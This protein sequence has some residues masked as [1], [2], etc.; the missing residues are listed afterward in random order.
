MKS[1]TRNILIIVA[2]IVV[3]V[4]IFIR[5]ISSSYDRA[6]G[7]EEQ[8]NTSWADVESSYQRRADLIPNLVNTVKG[9]AEH[10]QETL[11]QVMEARSKA[12]Q[13]NVNP[14]N[15][16]PEAIQQFQEAQQGV[17]SA[18]SRLLV[19]VERYPDLKAN[20]NFLELQAQ[21]EGTENR[22]NV[23]RTRYNETV[24][25]YN[26]FIRGFFK[27]WALSVSGGDFERKSPF[28]AREGSDIAPSVNF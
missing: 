16:T 11:T 8:V 23:A 10:E 19:V 14:E 9:Y 17:S 6:V 21:L 24:R 7:F 13:V 3:V 5:Y 18:L 22:I 15:L 4:F 20:Q 25:V 28:Q 27:R 1:R 12:T 2:V 26:T